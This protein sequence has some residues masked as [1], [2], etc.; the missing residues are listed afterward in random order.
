MLR[1]TVRRR[2][3]KRRYQKKTKEEQAQK[4]PEMQISV[5][6][7]NES[8]AEVWAA[9]AKGRLKMTTFFSDHVDLSKPR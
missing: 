1:Q 9:I 4:Q 8:V 3:V 7:A 5:A 2:L 6:E